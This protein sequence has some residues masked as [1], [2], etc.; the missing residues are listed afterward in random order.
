MRAGKLT[1]VAMLA[2]AASGCQSAGWPPWTVWPFESYDDGDVLTPVKR[3][4]QY[5]DL[6]E[7]ADG[8][9][10]QKQEQVSLMLAEQIRSEEDP[11]V[12]EQ[13]VRTLGSY[14]TATA[15]RM[16]WA[17][18]KDVQPGLG[19]QVKPATNVRIAACKTWGQRGGP[20]G[21]PRCRVS[22]KRKMTSTY[23]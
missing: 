18:L 5:A 4:E 10:P 7:S 22:C 2:F 6:A 3:I 13:I 15:E 19:G 14:R 23:G 12:R 8:Q 9:T 20:Q 21:S 1:I 17:A 16:L 11:L